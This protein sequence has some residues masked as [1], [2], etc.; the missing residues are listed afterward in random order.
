MV[1]LHANNAN[2]AIERILHLVPVE[3]HRQLLYDLSFN[4]KAIVASN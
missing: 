1:T 2:Q 4:L 3:K